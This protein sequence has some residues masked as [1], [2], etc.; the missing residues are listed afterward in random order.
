MP[1]VGSRSCG[2]CASWAMNRAQRR[3]GLLLHAAAMAVGDRGIVITGPKGAGKT[4]LLIHAL[5]ARSARYVSNDRVVVPAADGRAV[6]HRRADHRGAP[7]GH[8][9]PVP[10]ARRAHGR[11]GLRVSPDAGGSAG[12]RA[13]RSRL[14]GK[15][16]SLSPAQFCRLL[17]VRPLACSEIAAIVFPRIT[18]EPGTFALRRL[19]EAEV[20]EKIPDML[21]GVRGGSLHVERVRGSGRAAAGSRR[22]CRALSRYRVAVALRRVPPRPQ[23]LRRSRRGRRPDRGDPAPLASRLTTATLLSGIGRKNH[24]LLWLRQPGGMM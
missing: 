10:V 17:D 18:G 19:T 3:G 24:L 12:R 7:T 2:S 16:D 1:T 13:A 14:R 11:L 5:R 9:R 6:G 22:A 8:A 15:P 20:V 23:R 4:S 21:F